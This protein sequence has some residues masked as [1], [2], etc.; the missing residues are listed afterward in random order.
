MSGDLNPRM[1]VLLPVR[2]AAATLEEALASLAAQTIE[3]F[4]VLV[5]D[6]GSR[7]ASPAIARA[8]AARDPRF[9]VESQPPE[10]IVAALNAAARRARGDLLVRMD[11]DDVSRPDR[12]ARLAAYADEHPD[13]AFF[14]SRIQY[15]PRDGLSEGLL[16]YEAWINSLL[17]HEAIVRDRFV[18]CPLPHPAWAIRRG[19]FE[20]LGAYHANEFPEDYDLF[21]RAAEAGLR[22][23]KV[24]ACLLDWRD[25]PAR[26]SRTDKR[27]GL[28]RFFAL[29][30]E[31]VAPLLLERGRD[32]AVI[33]GG[34][35][36]KRWVR[37]LADR[38]VSV[39][40]LLDTNPARQ[41]RTI[42]GAH[43]LPATDLETVRGSFL[44]VALGR[45]GAREAMRKTLTATGFTEEDD[46]LCVQ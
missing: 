19:A 9:L 27:F 15:V 5:Q 17:V 29:K 38:G 28:D 22:F 45:P 32:V 34:R 26:M 42:H 12:L 21:L 31:H 11:A 18:E 36:G 7:D 35:H 41:G 8:Y 2:D 40:H 23:G 25:H 37:A 3:D 14:A 13:V 30:V 16:R 20:M 24:D 44:L 10:G 46:Y 43:V 39:P 6:D 33:G 1:S 4:E